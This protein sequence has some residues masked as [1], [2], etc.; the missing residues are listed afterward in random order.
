[1]TSAVRSLKRN[2][3]SVGVA[4]LAIL[5]FSAAIAAGSASAATHWAVNANNGKLPEG[6]STEVVG[7]PITSTQLSLEVWGIPLEM[8]CTEMSMKGT[9][10]NPTGGGSGTLSGTSMTFSPCTVT[11]PVGLGCVVKGKSISSFPLEGQ[12]IEQSGKS[13]IK[14]VGTEANFATFTIEGCTGTAGVLFDRTYN[15]RGSLTAFPSV[16]GSNEYEFKG[17][18]LNI[19][20]EPFTVFNRHRLSTVKGENIFSAR[21]GGEQ[22]WYLGHEAELKQGAPATYSSG[23][24]SFNLESE[25]FSVPVAIQCSGGGGGLSGVVENP[26]GGGA[27]TATGQFTLLGCA[28]KTGPYSFGCVLAP[29]GKTPLYSQSLSG[30]AAGEAIQLSPAE[31]LIAEFHIEGCTGGGAALNRT[32]K[33]KGSIALTTSSSG[34]LLFSGK[35]LTLGGEEASLSGGAWLQTSAGGTLT[36]V[37]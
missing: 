5:A 19:G 29:G 6:T 7:K 17:G 23:S 34:E 33:L 12:A 27:A 25:F 13:A 31:K 14:Y 18:E 4:L 35:S 8:E 37:P 10:K 20:G 9:A 3:L 32:Y 30:V 2:G 15:V 26:A 16:P 36:L 21:S 28:V 11:T 22:Y 24:M 1:M